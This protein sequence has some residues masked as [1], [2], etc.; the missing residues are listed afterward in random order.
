[1]YYRDRFI[2]KIASLIES[3]L[4]LSSYVLP[5]PVVTVLWNHTTEKVDVGRTNSRRV[6]SMSL[7]R[8]ISTNYAC[9]NAYI[10]VSTM[11]QDSVMQLSE[12]LLTG[13][14]FSRVKIAIEYVVLLPISSFVTA[15]PQSGYWYQA[16]FLTFYCLL[17]ILLLRIKE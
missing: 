11:L 14:Q 4:A 16:K 1:M 10:R 9:T 12:L 6:H 15:G 13:Y 17:V 3:Y 8:H 5:Y 7:L 2:S